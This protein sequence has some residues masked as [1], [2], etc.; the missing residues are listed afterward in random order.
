MKQWVLQGKYFL[1]GLFV[2]FLAGEGGIYGV[3]GGLR[4]ALCVGCLMMFVAVFIAEGHYV[5]ALASLL[6]GRIK[7]GENA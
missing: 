6:H 7:G 4:G 5:A 3:F 1:E 2:D